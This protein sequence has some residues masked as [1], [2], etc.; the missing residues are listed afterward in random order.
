MI[1]PFVIADIVSFGLIDD[2]KNVSLHMYSA[3]VSDVYCQKFCWIIQYIIR[4][5]FLG[6]Q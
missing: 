6:D 3:A 1:G 5:S 2:S 4:I